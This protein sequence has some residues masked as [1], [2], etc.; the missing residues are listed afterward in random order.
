MAAAVYILCAVTAL[1]C[2]WM[3]LRGYHRSKVRLL[4]WGALCF[5]M[6]VIDNTMLFVDLIIVPDINLGILRGL[7]A[8]S[9]VLFLL[10]GLIW[11]SK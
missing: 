2:F 8:L 5:L 7:A 6:F 10:Y 9:G 1:I 3:L 11:E 4:F